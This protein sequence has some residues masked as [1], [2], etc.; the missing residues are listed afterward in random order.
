MEEDCRLKKAAE[1]K[2]EK[3]K[4]T[5]DKDNDADANF[6]RAYVARTTYTIAKR[7]Y[8]KQTEHAGLWTR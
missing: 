5:E 2:R 6:A 1:R 4:S 3:R 8:A 7:N